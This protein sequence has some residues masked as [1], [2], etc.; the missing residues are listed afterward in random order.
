MSIRS[1]II[2]VRGVTPLLQNNPQTVDR[3][4]KFAKRMAVINA[5]KTRRTDDDF[6]ELRDLEMEAKVY[7]DADIGVYVPSSWVA[8]AIA[9]SAFKVAKISRADIRG[10][11][12]TTEDKLKL[13]Y[14]D[15]DKVKG[16]MD[17]VKNE[18]FRQMLTLPQGQ[19]RVVKAFPIF[20]KWSFETTLEFDDK[21]IDPD[22]LT[23]IAEHTAKYGGFGDFRPKF[24]RAIAEVAHV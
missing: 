17:I 19:V 20:H 16:I 22:S 2:S 13:S 5:K 4:N 18:N 10:A 9:T 6:L 12:F 24:G 7:F 23:R 15:S 21:I 1:A 14:R 8:E 11:M 3:F